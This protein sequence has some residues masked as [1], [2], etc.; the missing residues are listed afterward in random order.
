MLETK[1]KFEEL[2]WYVYILPQNLLGDSSAHPFWELAR[3]KMRA[4]WRG[5]CA[6]S[7]S[8]CSGPAPKMYRRLGVGTREELKILTH[9]FR[10]TL[11]YFILGWKI[12]K[13]GLN[14]WPPSRF[15]G[16]LWFRNV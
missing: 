4:N 5:K 12:G 13:I 3:T 7:P 15:W 14:F 6:E 8:S 11:P 16:S 10:P 2:L 9:I 1:N